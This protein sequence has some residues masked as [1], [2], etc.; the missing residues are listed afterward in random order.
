MLDFGDYNPTGSTSTLVTI[1]AYNASNVAVASQ[2]L[3]YTA[4]GLISPL[5]GNLAITGDAISA[6]PGQ[7]GN[8]TWN[9]SGSGIVRVVLDFGVGY[10]PNIGLDLLSFTVECAGTIIAPPGAATLVSPSG[11]ITDTT[12]AFTWN[13]VNAA[14]WYY[15]WVNGPS[16]NVIKQWYETS[17]VCGAGT[18]SVTPATTL[19]GGAHTWW[20]Q[21]WNTDGYGPWST[22]MDFSLPTIPPPGAATPVSPTGNITDTT[23]AY[24]WNKVSD[25]T[26]YY[27]WVDDSSGNVI[28]QWFETSTVCGA[29]SCS[30]TP[31]TTLGGGAH[32]FWIQTWNSAGYGPWSSS[33]NFSVGP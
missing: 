17:A 5:Y 30:V 32:T 23:P 6:I 4:V 8:W 15:L 11:S 27:L 9:V 21:T 14:T 7:P 29:S 24:T 31:A 22:S 28:K 18:C 16:G 20:I 10:D 33:M 12:P 2:Q 19:G 1:T 13:K 25:A 3:S 26:W